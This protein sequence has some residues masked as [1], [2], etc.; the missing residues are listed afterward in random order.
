VHARNQPRMRAGL[1]RSTS[2]QELLVLQ[3]VFLWLTHSHVPQNGACNSSSQK[4]QPTAS[5]H[6]SP[7]LVSAT[8]VRG[9][10]GHNV[11]REG[12]PALQAAPRVVKWEAVAHITYE[13][14]VRRR[15]AK[16][17]LFQMK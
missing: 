17:F 10:L 5:I 12:S 16:S 13:W 4:R 9:V 2:H 3:V 8:R 6:S 14:V 15:H 1:G 11:K 7:T